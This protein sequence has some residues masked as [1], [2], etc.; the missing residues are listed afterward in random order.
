MPECLLGNVVLGNPALAVEAQIVAEQDCWDP[1]TDETT[2]W[3]ADT[4]ETTTWAADTD[5]TTSWV[6]TAV[7][8]C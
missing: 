2:T 5:E 6:R 1:D 3:S 4:D 7:E 8:E